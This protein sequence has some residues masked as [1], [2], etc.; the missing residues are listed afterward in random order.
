MEWISLNWH[1]VLTVISTLLSF[2]VALAQLLHRD[3]VAKDLKEL[4]DIIA[5]LQ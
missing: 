4:E 2:G 3:R 1:G 5:R